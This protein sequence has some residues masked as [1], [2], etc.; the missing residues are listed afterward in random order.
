M[1]GCRSNLKPVVCI[2]CLTTL[3]CVL[4]WLPFQQDGGGVAQCCVTLTSV[5][6]PG[7]KQLL[8]IFFMVFLYCPLQMN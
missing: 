4:L 7:A 3:V 5:E 8:Y 6:E 2:V 1:S